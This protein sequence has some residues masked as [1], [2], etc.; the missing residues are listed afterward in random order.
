MFSLGGELFF[1]GLCENFFRLEFF[2]FRG[3][4][5]FPITSLLKVTALN[6]SK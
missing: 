1:R 3:G 6:I 5:G 4:E 2:F